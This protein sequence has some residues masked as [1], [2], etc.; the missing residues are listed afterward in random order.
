[1]SLNRAELNLYIWSGTSSNKPTVAN[2]IISKTK[3]T[4]HSDINFEVGELINDFLNPVFN[5]DY[6]S[7]TNGNIDCVFVNAYTRLFDA[8]DVSYDYNNPVDVTY[9]AVNGYGTFE[10]GTNPELS[11]NALITSNNVYV[12]ENTASKIPIFAEG[13]GKFIIGSSTT[14]VTD[15]ANTNQKIQY[16]NVPANSTSVAIY[17]TNDSTLLKTIIVHNICEPKFTSYKITFLNKYGAFQDLYFFKKTV[18]K[19]NVTDSTYK[20]NIIENETGTYNTYKGQKQRY[21]VNAKTSLTM[22]TGF[23]DEDMNT[24]IEE[25]FL[26][27]NIWIRYNN[28][29]LPVM[30]TNKSLQYKTKL[31]DKLI[32]YT[33]DFEFAF[34][35]INNVR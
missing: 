30:P 13:V 15:N 3:L 21:N 28:K 12:P 26:S 22:N 18:E 7:T 32:D 25:L 11:R 9:L 2:F 6:G 5:N 35:K 23:I 33:I 8:D 19:F 34:N 16:I 27:E 17:D 4:T 29:T 10:D 20:T 24:T 31:N 1:M 14:Q